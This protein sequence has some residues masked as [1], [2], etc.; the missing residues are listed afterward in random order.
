M[1]S[2]ALNRRQFLQVSSATAALSLGFVWPDAAMAAD[3]TEVNAWI[4][5]HS[6]E[7]IVIRYARTEM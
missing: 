3:H 7:S 4:E 1:N 6:D 2:T 5:I